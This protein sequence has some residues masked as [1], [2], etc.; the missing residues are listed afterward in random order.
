MWLDLQESFYILLAEYLQTILLPI[1]V[2]G[3]VTLALV[4]P[5]SRFWQPLDKVQLDAGGLERD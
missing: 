2:A 3:G 5:L 1:F 4:Y